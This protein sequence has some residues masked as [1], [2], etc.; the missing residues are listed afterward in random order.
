MYVIKMFLCWLLSALLLIGS[1][2]SGLTE[3]G[4]SRERLVYFLQEKGILPSYEEAAEEP[5]SDAVT[6]AVSAA[7]TSLPA[8]EHYDATAFYADCERLSALAKEDDE[9]AVRELYDSLYA[10]LCHIDTLSAT[11]YVL[12]SENTPDESLA[13]EDEY[14]TQLLTEA[15]DA[16]SL[17]CRAVLEGPCGE[18]FAQYL[19]E[20]T[21]EAL[22]DYEALTDRQAEL[23]ARETQ[24]QQDYYDIMGSMDDYTYRYGGKDWCW[25]DLE[26]TAGERLYIYDYNGYFEVYYGILEAV[27]EAAG[28]V[29]LELVRLRT[30]LAESYGYDSYTDYAYE[31]L[32]GRDYTPEQAQALCDEVKQSVSPAY[33]SEVYYSDYWYTDSGAEEQYS[34]EE[35]L[36]MLELCARETGDSSA[37][38][39]TLL[40]ENNLYSIGA[41]SCRLDGCYET[42]L[43]EG[44][45]PF[46]Y[47]LLYGGAMDFID[48]S[49]EFGHFTESARVEIP[50]ILSAV[51]NIDIAE[52][53]SN[54]F[55]LLCMRYYDEIFPGADTDFL[56][57]EN[58]ADMMNCVV[59]GCL[60]DEFQR[61]VYENPDRSLEEV[62]ILF[63]ELCEEYGEYEDTEE[64]YYW[65]LVGH[66]YDAPLYYISYCVSALAA[67]QIW[68]QSETDFEAAA[69]TWEA[70]VD[71]GCFNHGYLDALEAAGLRSFTEAGAAED[72]C[73]A[74]LQTLRELS[75]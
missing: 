12:Y 5:D 29:F 10:E 8:Y 14:C 39:W 6:T 59:S 62:N 67:L 27:N 18:S 52:I 61:R 37:E 68:E 71:Y 3:G 75:A 48:L 11:A 69:D 73:A 25:S 4:N 19:G 33:Y 43:S 45:V 21:A 70:I 7:A 22:R 17:A 9:E 65:M 63:R 60:Y 72:I 40:T 47:M 31:C 46:I 53:H 49:H 44:N 13:A 58:L 30:D 66:N 26:G 54:G 57:F 20:D 64:D 56:R 16:L 34:A 74:A 2:C 51:D 15:G 38:A 55:Q 41:E 23:L 36:S 42:C 24:L 50:N 28:P 35:L 32:Y 1:L